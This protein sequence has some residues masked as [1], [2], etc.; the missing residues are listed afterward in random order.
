[1]KVRARTVGLLS[2]AILAAGCVF[3]ARGPAPAIPSRI[4]A[5]FPPTWRFDAGERAVQAKRGMVVSNSDIA[6]R[7][8]ADIMKRGGN[9]VDAAVAVGFALTVTLPAAGNIGGGGFM[10]MRLANG[11]T[12]ALDYREVAPLAASRD[13]YLDSTGKLSDR[14]V[15]GHLASGVPGSVAGMAE[16]LRSH[17]TMTLAQVIAPAIELAERGWVIDSNFSRGL[18][19]DS[20]LVARFEGRR[21]FFPDGRAIPGGTLLRQRELAWTLR[22]IAERGA[23]GFYEG[24][25]ADSLVAEMQ[26][27]GGII[28]REDLKRYTPIWRD[29]VRGTYRGYTLLSMPPSSSGG[30]TMVETLNMLET[31]ERPA[32]YGSTQWAHRLAESYQRAFLDRNSKLGDP[33]FIQVPQQQLTSKEYARRLRETIDESRHTPTAQVSVAADGMHTTHYSV[34]DSAGNAVAVTTTLNGGYGSGVW[35][36]GA[37]F[38]MNNEM[39]DFA[40]QPGSPN[41]FGLVQGEQNAIA[42]GKRMLSAMSPTV[43]LDSVGQVL[44]IVGGAGGPTIITGTSQVVLNV[45]DHRMSLADAMRA[46]RL[47]HQSLP[48]SLVFERGGLWP[49]VADSLRAMGHG[50]REVRALVNMNA[51]MRVRGGWQGV[52]EPRSRGG[53]AGY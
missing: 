8:G 30:V 4:E 7:V 9:A 43:V 1:M 13:M 42:P 34:V 35:V 18:G 10:V 31:W 24:P 5:R 12:L 40:A 21:V 26:R 48:D 49:A 33:E 46:P 3:A 20:G 15:I 39:D 32:P 45:I 44:L 36:R 19:S 52:P 53:A 51:I 14:S 11:Q 17:G 23:A 50:L 29:P 28:T 47:H 22:Q 41:M 38:F 37:G 25:V 16:A 6:S 2:A 27:G